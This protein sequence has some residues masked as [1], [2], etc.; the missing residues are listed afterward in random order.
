MWGFYNYIGKKYCNLSPANLGC[1]ILLYEMSI[2]V[3]IDPNYTLEW[4][5][6]LLK[7]TDSQTTTLEN[8]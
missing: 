4:T 8:K 6:E 7:S 5:E 1:K 3:L 2:L